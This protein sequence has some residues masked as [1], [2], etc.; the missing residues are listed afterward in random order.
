L[1]EPE[2]NAG[3]V[4]VEHQ[5]NNIDKFLKELECNPIKRLGALAQ[6]INHCYFQEKALADDK[7]V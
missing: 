4:S 2:Y 5:T 3:R 1:S 6:T 7:V